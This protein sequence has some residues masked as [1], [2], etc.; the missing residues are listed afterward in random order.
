M[1]S[2]ISFVCYAFVDDTDLVHTAKDTHTRGPE[3]MMEMQQ[4]IDHYR[5]RSST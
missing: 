4:A 5:R 3:V 1:V 2:V